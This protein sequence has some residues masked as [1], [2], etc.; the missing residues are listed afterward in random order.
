MCHLVLHAD[1]RPEIYCAF[2]TDILDYALPE[3]FS[4]QETVN[5]QMAD[6]LDTQL[7]GRF[8]NAG[9]GDVIRARWQVIK[10]RIERR[11]AENAQPGMGTDRLS[12]Y[13]EN[14]VERPAIA[15]AST[16]LGQQQLVGV[17]PNHHNGKYEKISRVYQ[18]AATKAG[19]FTLRSLA[20]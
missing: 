3:D 17:A 4:M 20:K 11:W 18:N 8:A 14:G 9:F 16:R 19:Y 15:V 5:S 7:G 13:L 1:G 10:E 2:A 12:F 6:A